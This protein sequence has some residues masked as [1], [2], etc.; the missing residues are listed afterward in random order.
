MKT[1]S[2]RVVFKTKSLCHVHRPLY[3]NCTYDPTAHE[4][5]LRQKLF[6]TY[7]LAP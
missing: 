5:H 3:E 2:K 1:K 4:L 7:G 6:V